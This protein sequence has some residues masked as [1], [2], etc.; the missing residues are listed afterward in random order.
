M[1]RSGEKFVPDGSDK[2]I[3]RKST[4]HLTDD[5]YAYVVM[6]LARDAV[7]TPA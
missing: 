7:E 4:D 5:G 1:R 6:P 3:K 2:A